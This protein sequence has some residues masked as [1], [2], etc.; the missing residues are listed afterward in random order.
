MAHYK[1]KC[2]RFFRNDFTLEDLR[3]AECVRIWF[4]KTQIYDAKVELDIERSVKGE[5][6]SIELDPV[7]CEVG[8]YNRNQP[9][10]RSAIH[11]TIF[12]FI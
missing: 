9:K 10:S 7:G 3:Q 11:D 12:P 2:Y 5:Y 4:D 6:F 1:C 8:N